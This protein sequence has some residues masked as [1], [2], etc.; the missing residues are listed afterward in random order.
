MSPSPRERK[1]T[2]FSGKGRKHTHAGEGNPL[3][4][5]Q[6]PPRSGAEVRGKDLGIQGLTADYVTTGDNEQHLWISGRPVFAV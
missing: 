3:L 6:G 5:P 2:C 4:M 1:V